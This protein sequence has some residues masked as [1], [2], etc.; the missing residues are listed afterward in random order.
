MQIILQI[1]SHEYDVLVVLIELTIVFLLNG[2]NFNYMKTCLVVIFPARCLH[3]RGL[4][5]SC[6]V[7]LSRS[8]IVSKR[9]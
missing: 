3:K 8:C 6:G 5:P 1:L 7:C 2:E 4:M 9:P